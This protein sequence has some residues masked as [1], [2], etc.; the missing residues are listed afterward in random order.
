MDR[1]LGYAYNDDIPPQVFS[2]SSLRTTYRLE[3]GGGESDC[4]QW[5]LPADDTPQ[6]VRFAEHEEVTPDLFTGA[7]YDY[8]A[9]RTL[10][11]FRHKGR[12]VF[13][14]LSRQRDVSDVGKKGAALGEEGNW[15]YLYSGET[16][17]NKTGLGW[18]KSYM[19]KSFSV[20]VFYE[21]NSPRP[22]LLCGTFKWLNA[23]WAG[24]NM[25]KRRHI[26]S[27]LHRYVRDFRGI[28]EN[29]KLP[30]HNEMADGFTTL[31]N[32][33]SEELRP[34]LADYLKSLASQ[35][36]TTRTLSR[37]LFRNLLAPEKYLRL[38]DLPEMRAILELEYLKALLGKQC[39]LRGLPT[40]SHPLSVSSR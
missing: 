21:S 15:D 12:N 18:V 11:L 33:S 28:I 32:L 26:L 14:S 30:H 13:I 35:Y 31:K 25:V 34:Y 37:G 22:R 40:L 10:I 24:I 3:P 23:G 38:L 29:K 19:Y 6:I 8:D 4:W 1:L 9:D 27:G 17:L 7:Y 16:G 20:T 36:A 5:R 39:K 2:P